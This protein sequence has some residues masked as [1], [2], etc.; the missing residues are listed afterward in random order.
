MVPYPRHSSVNCEA[1]M[2]GHIIYIQ[3]IY[4]SIWKNQENEKQKK[5][6]FEENEDQLE[7]KNNFKN[8][9]IHI[10]L[11]FEHVLS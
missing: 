6:K 3:L 1:R 9:M 4:Q 7:N 11:K 2:V 8:P 5:K 10:L